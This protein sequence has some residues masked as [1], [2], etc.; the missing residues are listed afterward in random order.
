MTSQTTPI[1]VTVSLEPLDLGGCL[2]SQNL[3]NGHIMG[4]QYYMFMSKKSMVFKIIAKNQ[5]QHTKKCCTYSV[6]S[7]LHEFVLYLMV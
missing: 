5:F 6:F 1:D 7:N 4:G 3:R 2:T